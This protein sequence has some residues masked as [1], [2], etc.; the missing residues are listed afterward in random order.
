MTDTFNE[1]I[2]NLRLAQAFKTKWRLPDRDRALVLAAVNACHLDMPAIAAFCRQLILQNNHGHMVRKWESINAALVD[3]DFLH[4]CKQLARKLPVEQ[5]ETI[6]QELGVPCELT[7]EDFP[8]NSTYAAAILGV[9]W[10][11]LSQNFG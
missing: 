8:D 10:D 1:L 5:A 9:E 11:W 7:A 3:P 4:F 2:L 6:L